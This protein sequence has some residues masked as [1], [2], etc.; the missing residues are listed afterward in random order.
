MHHAVGPLRVLGDVSWVF[1]VSNVSSG[2]RR[3]TGVPSMSFVLPDALGVLVSMSLLRS[4]LLRPDER[5][6]R[7]GMFI[8]LVISLGFVLLDVRMG[9]EGLVFIDDE[10]V[11]GVG[12]SFRGVMVPF[13]CSI[14]SLATWLASA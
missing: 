8:T 5:P 9:G 3:S 11:G 1:S 2:P 14:T 13:A 12:L 7:I 4:P 10:I 6:V